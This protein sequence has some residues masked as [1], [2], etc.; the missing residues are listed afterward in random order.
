VRAL[1]LTA[2]LGT[3]LRPL[4]FVRAK[5]AVPVNGEPIV[6]RVISWLAGQGITDLVLNLHHRPDS[7]TAV[8]G[9]GGDLGVR[10]RYSW[11]NRVLGSAGGPRRALPLLVDRPGP[12]GGAGESAFILV[13]GD[14]M[15]D[16]EMTGLVDRHRSSGAMVT[17]ALIP[18]P[19]P[20]LYGGVVVED[21][22][23]AGFTSRGASR[24]NFH[25]VGIQVTDAKVFSA[26]EDG[27]PAETVM[28]LYPRLMREQRDAIAA[29]VV[30][31][32]F[33]DV[34]T[35]ADYLDSSLELAGIE[36]DRLVSRTDVT[37]DPSAA[38]VRTA[39][40]NHVR[41]GAGA[42]LEDCIVCDGVEI[43]E[44]ARYSRCAIVPYGGQPLRGRERVDGSL[45]V[46]A[47]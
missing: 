32:R 1:I 43:R 44:G 12:A 39:V 24:E 22:R 35:P 23:V 18:N 45:V 6:R 15:T 28:Q 17:M 2:G 21:G 13:N 38:I 5:A 29:H 46:A 30:D 47:F 8:V 42:R 10:V 20:E 41:I 40:W 16:L 36:G 3:R 37:I 27:V 33:R 34:G 9:D 14:T 31:A 26:L 19:R 25:F 11:E 7:I 4:T